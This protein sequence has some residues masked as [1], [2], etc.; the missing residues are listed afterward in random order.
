MPKVSW[1]VSYGFV[2]N[3]LHFSAVQ[4]F[5]KL[6]KF[7]QTYRQFKGGNFF[8]D[9]VYII[10]YIRLTAFFQDNLGRPAPER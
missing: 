3:F 7:W 5:W 8:W 4:K 6:A 2:A 1:L 10:H 9:T